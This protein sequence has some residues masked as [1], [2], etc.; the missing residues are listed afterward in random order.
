[1]EKKKIV[2]LLLSFFL[3][4]SSLK[5]QESDPFYSIGGVVKDF[6]TKKKI[7]HVTVSALGTN[8]GTISNE[9]GEFVL[10]LND[11]L[12]VREIELSS[13]G[14]Y[15]ARI[16]ISNED[17]LGQEFF[18]RPKDIH[19]TEVEV[20]T[21][22]D[23]QD[24]I[25]AAV[26]RIGTNY[27]RSPNLLTGFYRETVQKGRK[28]INISEAVVRI[29]K[30]GYAMD[31]DADRVQIIKGRKLVSPKT[32][33]TLSVT[34]LGGPNL[35]IYIDVVKNPDL[36]L[37]PEFFPL[38]SYKMGDWVTI[39]DRIQYVVHFKSS[40]LTSI[41][42]YSGTFYIDRETLAFTRAEF[43]MDMN[44]KSKATDLILRRKPKGLR[45]SPTELTY[46]I[47]YK[48]QNGKSYLNYIRNEIRFKCDW[49]RRIFATNYTVISEMVITDKQDDN[50][51]RIPQK[52]A[53]S[54]RKSLSNEAM[55]YYDPDFW[56]AYNIIEP[57]ES[58]ESAVG[59]LKRTDSPSEDF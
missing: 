3:L 45:F 28:Y 52:Q 38:Y 15:N 40:V 8:V 37:D 50:V 1:M 46:V 26:E 55:V 56:G 21:W 59:K 31:V 34:L 51:S 19:L 14:Y 47:N 35:A 33:D 13:M 53:F 36:I 10:K 7:E 42:L 6:R 5:A 25:E 58:L 32:T 39:N 57:T 27:S 9:D 17:L 4:F 2:F 23:P 49:A 48:Q 54:E 22:R 20:S 24:L 43:T 12:N 44:D 29:F 41:P 18:L 16:P 30:T 11:T